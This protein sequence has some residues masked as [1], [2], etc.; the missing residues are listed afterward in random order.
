MIGVTCL[1]AKRKKCGYTLFLFLS[2]PRFDSTTNHILNI[3]PASQ[4]P[5]LALTSNNSSQFISNTHLA[6]MTP[7]PPR[8]RPMYGAEDARIAE[9][10]V[11]GII[12]TLE[13][14]WNKHSPI[15]TNDHP[16]ANSQP[17]PNATPRAA[18]TGRRSS[19]S[20]TISTTLP[21]ASITSILDRSTD[22][23]PISQES[24]E[25]EDSNSDY[26][27]TNL[28]GEDASWV[29]ITPR[30]RT[31]K[32]RNL[33][34][35]RQKED[36]IYESA[37]RKY[38]A[39]GGLP[40]SMVKKAGMKVKA[41]L[42]IEK[43]KVED[44]MMWFTNEM[45]GFAPSQRR[46][47]GGVDEENMAGVGAA[48][49]AEAGRG[50]PEFMQNDARASA[51][52]WSKLAQ[53][54]Q[55]DTR[56]ARVGSIDDG[57]YLGKPT[58]HVDTLD[59]RK[60]KKVTSSNNVS[61]RLEST[62]IPD[63]KAQ[64]QQHDNDTKRIESTMGEENS[65]VRR[66]TKRP[67]ALNY[68]DRDRGEAAKEQQRSTRVTH[69]PSTSG[70]KEEDRGRPATRHPYILDFERKLYRDRPHSKSSTE[71]SSHGSDDNHDTPD[72]P[73]NFVDYA[74]QYVPRDNEG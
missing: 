47:S 19:D 18:I 23:T 29:D 4:N 49:P 14:L 41:F 30:R 55:S 74:S 42:G 15:P 28:T 64:E 27:I 10:I 1:V 54:F 20:P 26:E 66:S 60:S 68:D 17:D 33:S 48:H 37:R 72:E 36:P 13:N 22:I 34:N 2:H 62:S 73:R 51:M 70:A 35:S 3:T 56:R 57:E 46:G 40:G 69:N 53:N 45:K 71:W 12:N 31:D 16:S 11:G 9:P 58:S 52:V 65:Q 38:I 39:E 44:G 50:S 5:L 24:E 6:I 43:V 63:S 21:P 7:P 25:E 59:A 8:G 61:W 67:S 32:A